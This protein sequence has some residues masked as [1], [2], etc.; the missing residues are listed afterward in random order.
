MVDWL[1]IAFI[2]TRIAYAV[3]Y[4]ADLHLWRSLVWVTGFGICVALFVVAA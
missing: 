3:C 1:A 2:A 4:L